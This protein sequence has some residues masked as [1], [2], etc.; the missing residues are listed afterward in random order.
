VLKWASSFQAVLRIWLF[1]L[2]RDAFRIGELRFW[3]Q[4]HDLDEVQETEPL[5]VNSSLLANESK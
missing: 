2:A 4:V 5:V 3:I 1:N